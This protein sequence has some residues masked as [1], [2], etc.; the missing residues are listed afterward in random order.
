MFSIYILNMTMTNKQ[1]ER[2]EMIRKICSEM[3]IKRFINASILMTDDEKHKYKFKPMDIVKLT[4]EHYN[5]YVNELKKSKFTSKTGLLCGYIRY[6]NKKIP[7]SFATYIPT[8]RELIEND[9]EVKKNPRCIPYFKADD[10]IKNLLVFLL[11][12]KRLKLNLNESK[13]V[14]DVFDIKMI[15]L[16][17]I[18][19]TLYEGGEDTER[20]LNDEFGEYDVCDTITERQ[21]V[22]KIKPAIIK[23]IEK[24]EAH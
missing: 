12:V 24:L 7:I 10:E 4:I 18:D 9:E 6:K 20:E 16:C 1:V 5:D 19:Y 2:E 15:K 21:M 8:I 13:K 17:N 22:I 23:K 11:S 14:N 3:T